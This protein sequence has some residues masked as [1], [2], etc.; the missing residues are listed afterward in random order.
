VLGYE[1]FASCLV[2]FDFAAGMMDVW[3]AARAPR[4]LPGVAVPM[5]LIENHPYVEGDLKLPGRAPVHARFVIDTGSNAGLIL[6]PDVAARDTLARAFPRTLVVMGRGVGA[7]VR[8]HLGRAESL[9]LGA[10][11]FDR[12]LVLVPEPTA[13]RFS[14]PGTMGNIGGQLV[15]RCRVTFDYRHR[16]VGFEPGANF[17][18]AFEADMSGAAMMR[19]AHGLTVRFVNPGTPAADAGL[20][21]GDVVTSVDGAPAARID[22]AALQ[23][24]MRREGHEVRLGVRRGADSLSVTL[25]LR[26]LL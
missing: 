21:E 22:P 26:R 23:R 4:D 18:E 5:T 6:A 17:H 8:N 14:A 7:E 2:R 16:L 24:T 10:L 3:D 13:G 1:L 19:G 12:P 20:R 25:T 9:R 11:S 15:S